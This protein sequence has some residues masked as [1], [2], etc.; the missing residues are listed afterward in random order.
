MTG[1]QGTGPVVNVG[2]MWPS[3]SPSAFT[4]LSGYKA[5]SLGACV[6]KGIL[7]EFVC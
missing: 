4:M 5:A 2:R 3:M 7:V 1:R 6:E